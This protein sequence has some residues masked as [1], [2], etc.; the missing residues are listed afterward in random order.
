MT[1]TVIYRYLGT[2]GI[3]ESP[4]HLED[5]Y[6]V[7]FIKLTADKGKALTDGKRTSAVVLVPENEVDLWKEVKA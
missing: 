5:A 1:R 6:S 3:I 4:V 7:R 2:N